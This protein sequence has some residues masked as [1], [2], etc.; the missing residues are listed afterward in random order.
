MEAAQIEGHADQRPFQGSLSLPTQTKSSSPFHASSRA[1]QALEADGFAEAARR[2]CDGQEGV[3]FNLRLQA[4]LGILP[5]ESQAAVFGAAGWVKS[6]KLP[7]IHSTPE[8]ISEKIADRV[9]YRRIGCR[10]G[11]QGRAHPEGQ[12]S[13]QRKQRM[14]LGA[15]HQT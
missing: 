12:A 7:A 10:A 9:Q 5:F 13:T 15:N 1:A 8:L 6:A 14:Q 4:K 3:C 11:N 2:P